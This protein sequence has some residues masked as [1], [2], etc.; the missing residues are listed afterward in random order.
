[1]LHVPGDANGKLPIVCIYHGFTGNKMEPHFIFIKLSRLLEK[2]GIASVRFDFG[3]SGEGDGD[4]DGEDGLVF[5]IADFSEMT[6][7]P[8]DI[9]YI[10]YPTG[11]NTSELII[12]DSI[13]NTDVRGFLPLI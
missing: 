10:V 13:S 1:M 2:K 12:R 3:G 7:N 4:S 9:G 8:F 6:F 11:V 5:E